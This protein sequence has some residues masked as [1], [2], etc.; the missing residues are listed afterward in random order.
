MQSKHALLLGFGLVLAIT[1]ASVRVAYSQQEEFEPPI[2]QN[3]VSDYA[4]VL[5]ESG[6]GELNELLDQVKKELGLE[7]SILTIRTADPLP[8]N[9]YSDKISAA[10]NLGENDLKRKTLLFL[11][12]AEEGRYRLITNKGLESIV[13]DEQ[14]QQISE[15]VIKPAFEEGE[16]AKGLVGGIN[17]ILQLLTK[18]KRNQS[19]ESPKNASSGIFGASILGVL[20]IVA[21]LALVLVG[22]AL[23][24]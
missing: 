11:L 13:T 2:R 9:E 6:E 3:Y 10:W 19:P 7:I 4:Q 1:L 8:I 18:E 20:V 21:L 14:L 24:L 5:E 17:Q 22:A 23:L 15:T 12:A 16:Y